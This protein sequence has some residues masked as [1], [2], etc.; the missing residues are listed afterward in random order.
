MIILLENTSSLRT[1]KTAFQSGCKSILSY[2]LKKNLS[3]SDDDD[4]LENCVSSLQIL[5]EMEIVQFSTIKDTAIFYGQ[6]V[7][8]TIR[9][10][11]VSKIKINPA[12]KPFFGKNTPL[13]RIFHL[14]KY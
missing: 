10:S 6:V 1:V 2:N 12:L 7:Q 11:K 3:E 14:A 9:N 5:Q 4:S 13:C 8:V